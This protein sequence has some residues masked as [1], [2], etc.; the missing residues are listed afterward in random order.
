[1]YLALF[2]WVMGIP[3]PQLPLMGRHVNSC[4]VSLVYHKRGAITSQFHSTNSE[5]S[6][7]RL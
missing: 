5:I 4:S 7:G 1:M 2:W 6:G 3:P